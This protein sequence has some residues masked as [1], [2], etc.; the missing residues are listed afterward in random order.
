M[1]RSHMAHATGLA[2]L[3]LHAEAWVTWRAGA[4]ARAGPR[5]H[6]AWL[7][8]ERRAKDAGVR[9]F[10][11]VEQAGTN[12]DLWLARQRQPRARSARRGGARRAA[13]GARAL[14]AAGIFPAD[15]KPD[16]VLVEPPSRQAEWVTAVIDYG[17][18]ASSLAILREAALGVRRGARDGKCSRETEP[19]SSADVG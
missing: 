1:R 12:L 9:L 5:V 11:V 15:V 16:N 6:A 19:S 3:P 17:R 2:S 18:G 4:C 7:E 14:A 13:Q 10:L 8:P